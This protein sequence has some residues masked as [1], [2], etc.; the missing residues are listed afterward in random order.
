MVKISELKI[1]TKRA[2]EGVWFRDP[3]GV[4]LRFLIA[5]VH[6]P[7][8][9]RA[10]RSAQRYFEPGAALPDG[11]SDE[12]KLLLRAT[13][14]HLLLDVDGLEDDETGKP[15][16]YTPDMGVRWGGDP[17]MQHVLV[18]VMQKAQGLGDY[19]AKSRGD[20]GKP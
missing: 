18:W 12:E 20:A 14:E 13:A 19:L 6:S 2:A 8:F 3:W 5:S 1:D 15:V 16:H 9:V 11:E 7:A 4:G 10:V 17:A